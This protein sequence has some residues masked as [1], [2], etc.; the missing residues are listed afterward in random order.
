MEKCNK[1]NH[2]KEKNYKCLSVKPIHS[3]YK[4]KPGETNF[5]HRIK[6]KKGPANVG[7]N[8]LQRYYKGHSL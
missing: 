6:K 7:E 5:G 8:F 1:E 4:T 2:D 3:V